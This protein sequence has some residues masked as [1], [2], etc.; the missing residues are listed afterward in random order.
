MHEAVNPFAGAGGFVL[1]GGQSSRMG[2]DKALMELAGRPLAEH[3]VE[4]LRRVCSDVA[5][6]SSNPSLAA[7]APLLAD[8]HPGCGPIG[9][10]E[11]ALLGASFHWNLFLPVDVPFLPTVYLYGWLQIMHEARLRGVRVMMWTVNGVPQPAVV[12]VQRDVGPLLTQAIE[13]GEYKLRPALERAAKQAAARD[14]F[15]PGAGFWMVPYWSEMR[16]GSKNSLSHGWRSLTEAQR[17]YHEHWFDNLN[18]PEEFAEAERHVD[19]LD[20]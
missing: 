13:R 18:T 6:C 8:V 14:G 10:M 16:T 15:E 5:I 19:A 17:R 12:L 4:K 9:G 11:A 3:A 20:T 7:Y 2:R 1:A